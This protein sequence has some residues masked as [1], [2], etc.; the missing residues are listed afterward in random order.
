MALPA[1]ALDPAISL[2]ATYC[3]TKVPAEHDDKRA[4]ETTVDW[5]TRSS[6]RCAT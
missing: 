2:I 6:N 5:S 3:A 1:E 4:T